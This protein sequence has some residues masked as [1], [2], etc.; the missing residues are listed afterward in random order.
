MSLHSLLTVAHM[1]TTELLE[2][3]GRI[4]PFDQNDPSTYP[5]CYKSYDFA[6]NRTVISEVYITD[7][8]AAQFVNGHWVTVS[9][10]SSETNR[11]LDNVTSYLVI[12]EL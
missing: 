9:Y 1:S 11:R 10:D 3:S 2:K 8:G 7:K 4:K 12:T 5:K 6:G